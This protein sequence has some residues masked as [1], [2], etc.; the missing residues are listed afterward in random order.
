MAAAASALI[1]NTGKSIRDAC[2]KIGMALEWF[3]IHCILAPALVIL[4]VIVGVAA[5]LYVT[6]LIGLFLTAVGHVLL[7]PA[8]AFGAWTA[9]L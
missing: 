6:C 8:D 3:L 4:C 5:F 2:R 9:S 7:I 1:R